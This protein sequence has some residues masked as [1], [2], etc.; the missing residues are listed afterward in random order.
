[1]DNLSVEERI[2]AEAEYIVENG[3]T[4]RD[5]AKKFGLSKSAVHKDVSYKLQFIDERLF[6]ECRHVLQI[7][8]KERHIRGG[9]ATKKKYEQLKKFYDGNMRK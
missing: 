6:A 9:N 5:T 1:M 8:L 2:L 4:V 7:N 3:A